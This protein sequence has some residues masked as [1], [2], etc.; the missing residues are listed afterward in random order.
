M[1][2]RLARFLGK[3][4]KGSTLGCNT[5][6]LHIAGTNQVFNALEYKEIFKGSMYSL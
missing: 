5:R 3:I 1:L 2:V 4:Y 6:V